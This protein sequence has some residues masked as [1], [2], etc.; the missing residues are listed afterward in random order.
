MEPK[1]KAFMF[2]LQFMYASR[3]A[4]HVLLRWR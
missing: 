3:D 2:K 4:V 1:I